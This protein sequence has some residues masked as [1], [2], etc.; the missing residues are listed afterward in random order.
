[1]AIVATDIV[2]RLSGGASNTDPLLSLGGVKSS[3]VLTSALFDTVTSAQAAAGQ[4]D[5]RCFYVHNNHASLTLQASEIW[6]QANTT[7]TRI[8][9]GL[10]TS[11]LNGTEQTVASKTTAPVS[12]V[13]TTAATNYATGLVMGGIPP[14]QSYAV[15]LRRTVTAG[16]TSATDT[17]TMRTQGDTNP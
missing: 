16:A 1:M 8:A 13:F 14:G 9:V 3:S 15:W 7:N 6:I 2:Y 5:Y 10:G 4:T 12:V 11:G 17:F